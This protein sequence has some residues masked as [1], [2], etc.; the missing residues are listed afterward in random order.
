MST[1]TEPSTTSGNPQT[2]ADGV[3]MMLRERIRDQYPLLILIGLVIIASITSHAFLTT[4]NLTNLVSQLSVTGV[5]VLAELI[6]VISGGIDISVGSTLGLAAVMCAGLFQG[7]N[8]WVGF[9][10]ALATGAVIGAVNG[11]LVAFR[12]VDA[13]IVTLG[14][15]ALARGLVYAYTEGSPLS[16]KDV[17]FITPGTADIFGFPVLGLFWIA[18][19]AI[20]TLLLRRTVFGRRV[21]ATG[22]SRVAA[23]SSGLP[24]RGTIFFV[25][26]VAGILSGLAGFMLTSRVGAGTPSAGLSYELDAIAAVVIGGA[27]LNGGYGRVSGAVIG[28]FIFGVITNLLV[29]LN[30]S[31]FLQDAFKGA[32]ILVAVAVAAGKRRSP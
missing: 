10:V 21:Y 12:G 7:S 4:A 5:L 25:F 20:M 11:T 9:L 15:L 30:V 27:R 29:L 24:V 6:V 8:V 2:P 28:T 13:F 18:V 16:P 14:M 17:G 32:L 26:L 23:E 1:Q 22:S 19:I 3:A 31:T